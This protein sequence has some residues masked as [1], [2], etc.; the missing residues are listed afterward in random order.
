M[1]TKELIGSGMVTPYFSLRDV[2]L[3]IASGLIIRPGFLLFGAFDP[4]IDEHQYG[5][6][7][8]GDDKAYP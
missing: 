1:H 6:D 8:Y 2:A 7:Y 4:G 5:C 3:S